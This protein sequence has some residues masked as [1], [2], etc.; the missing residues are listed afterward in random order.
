[1]KKG[2]IIGIL[3]L[4]VA[5]GVVCV[6]TLKTDPYADMDADS[7]IEASEVTGFIGEKS[8]GDPDS[9]K[10]VIYEYADFGCSHCAE[11]NRKINSLMEKYDGKIARVFR[12]YDIGQFQNSLRAASAATA[13]AMQGHFG[14]YKDLLYSNQAEWFY[15]EGAELTELLLRYFEEASGGTGDVD[16]FQTDVKSSAVRTRLKFEQNM[17]KKVGLAGTPTF[18]IDGEAVSLSEL[19][20]TIERKVEE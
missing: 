18:R 9:A 14:E 19:V 7:I 13:A 5:V 20:E 6:A 1:M 16:K 12:S 2:M 11:W 10:V 15:A 17:G 3:V 8:A 4:A